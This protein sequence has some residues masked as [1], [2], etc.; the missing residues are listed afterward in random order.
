MS[1]DSILSLKNTT[2][3][4]LLEPKSQVNSQHGKMDEL[5]LR[6]RNSVGG[7]GWITWKKRQQKS[8]YQVQMCEI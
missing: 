7:I 6:M 8:T 5:D 2:Q 1:Y 3:R 4:H